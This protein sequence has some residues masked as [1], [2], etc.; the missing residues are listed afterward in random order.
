VPCEVINYQTGAKL[1]NC[2]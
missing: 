1:V 2:G